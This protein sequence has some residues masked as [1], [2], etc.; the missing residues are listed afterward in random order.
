MGRKTGNRPGAWGIAALVAFAIVP[1]PAQAQAP[2][3]ALSSPLAA[4]SHAPAAQP[5]SANVLAA[6]PAAFERNVGQAPGGVRFLTRGSGYSLQLERSGATLALRKRRLRMRFLDANPRP[7][8]AGRRR[9]KATASYFLGDEPSRWHRGV[10]MFSRVRYRRLWAGIDAVFHGVGRTLEYDF[11][12]APGADPE[13]IGVSFGAGASTTLD[14]QGALLVRVGD[15]TI[16]QPRPIGY[17]VI[18]GRRV[19]VPVGYEISGRR[20]GF[21][22]G[23]Y[24]HAHRLVIDP[25]LRYSTY[26]GGAS[27]DFGNAIAVDAAGNAYVA[28]W[29]RSSGMATGGAHQAELAGLWDAFVTK[30][31]AS[32]SL[33]YTTYLGGTL[34]SGNDSD[35]AHAIAVDAEGNAYVAGG[36]S[37]P[38]FPTTPGAYMRGAPSGS[39]G[40]VT[41]LNP[42]GSALVYST[43]IGSGSGDVAYGIAVDTTGAAYV[44][45]RMGKGFSTLSA[46][47]PAGQDDTDAFVAKFNPAGSALVYGTY[48]G[49]S[50]YDV[51]TSITHDASGA[52]YVTGITHSADFPMVSGLQGTRAGPADAFVTKISTDGKAFVYSTFLGGSKSDEGNAIAVDGAGSAY[53]TGTARSADFPL[54][55]PY[56]DTRSSF[57]VSA[58]VSKLTPSGSGLLYSTYFGEY[59]WGEGI[60]VD[61]DGVAHVAGN[62]AGGTDVYGLKPSSSSDPDAFAAKFSPDG[63]SVIYSTSLGGSLTDRARGIAIDGARNQYVTGYTESQNFPTVSAFQDGHS[64]GT[65]DAYVLKID[66]DTEPPGT[67]LLSGPPSTDTNNTA[68][69][70]FS[71]TEPGTFECKLDAGAF[72]SCS[73]PKTYSLLADGQHSFSV[74]ALDAADNP[75]RSPVT[76]IWT[77][78]ASPPQTAIAGSPPSVTNTSASF[79]FESD[80]PSS[81]FECRIDNQGFA[82]CTSPKAYSG[83]A[84]GPHTFEVRATDTSGNTDLSPATWSWTVDVFPPNTTINSGP[85]AMTAETVASFTFSSESNATF[86]CRLDEGLWENCTSPRVY[87]ALGDGPHVFRARASDQVGNVDQ[88]PAVFDWTIE[89]ATP[90][91]LIETSPPDLSNSSS[92][93]F[94]FTA[95]EPAGFEC[96]L[97]DGEWF[98]CVSPHSLLGLEDGSHTFQARATDE[99]G[100]PDPTPAGWTW[101][102]DTQAPLAFAQVAPAP[103]AGGLPPAPAPVFTWAP[104][105]DAGSGVARFELWLDAQ[106]VA[107]VL[108][109]KC[110]ALQCSA[111]GPAPMQEGTHSWSVHAIDGAGNIRKTP[112]RAFSVD[113][114]PPTGLLLAEPQDGR[115]VGG[116]RPQLSWSRPVDAGSGVA[117]YEVTVD[118]GNSATVQSESHT[119]GA[120][121]DD[122]PHTW[123][124]VAVDGA[125]NRSAPVAGDFVVDTTPPLITIAP[126]PKVLVGRAVTVDASG[127]ADPAGG[128]IVKFDF[129]LDGD[130][131]FE[132]AATEPRAQL[133]MQSAGVRTVRVRGTDEVGNSSV[134]ETRAEAEAQ[135]GSAGPQLTTVTINDGAFATNSL[136]VTLD[137]RPPTRAGVVSML[138]S[139]DGPPGPEA[140]PVPVSGPVDDLRW[141]LGDGDGSKTTRL[142]YVFFLNALGREVGSAPPDVIIYDPAPPSV[143]RPQVS[144]QGRKRRLRVRVRDR[145]SGIRRIDVSVGRRRIARRRPRH[146]RRGEM[147]ARV[148]ITRPGRITIRAFD[149]A[150]NVTTS[151]AG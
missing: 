27:Q 20:I 70:S 77:V 41:K 71:S 139:N 48:L 14:A 99:A 24:D 100:K 91:T 112:D 15:D 97:D 59:A 64:G 1:V 73:S 53:V 138:I 92:A 88:T 39:D 7:R 101:T 94:T 12:V 8:V 122:G 78:Q 132:G 141:R 62:A 17:Q 102:V 144:G 129:D 151:R 137:I 124:V 86:E 52:T 119:P 28:G 81:T 146:N 142:V 126:L 118:G 38:N 44:T 11:E 54:V 85:V 89:T 147:V 29:T 80:R 103:D 10:P 150:G 82:P 61:A 74:R 95:T 127:S 33:V 114:S 26:L 18:G 110:S 42:A 3:R 47:Q 111:P 123:S 72:T 35:E 87:S 19:S 56:R 115:R 63:G 134:G 50:S 130:G 120:P 30:V 79:S 131:S 90:D 49:G 98:A 36:T 67:A 113:A 69:F 2:F 37:S 6:A 83:L 105:T 4:L 75:D 58:F 34:P 65:D 23:R 9:L 108:P 93:S 55:N 45:G 149:R 106:K 40:F 121:L 136:D 148:R 5:R 140:Q 22:I 13:I 31:D 143:G 117:I 133:V 107:T 128:R 51:A 16:R 125:G 60:A 32:G 46:A 109:A 84:G 135:A 96:R 21:R 43:L 116:A 25:I 66:A 76:Y 145:A 68:T 57:G 104:T